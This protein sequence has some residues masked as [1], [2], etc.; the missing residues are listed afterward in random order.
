[1]RIRAALS[2]LPLRAVSGAFIVNSGLGKRSATPERAAQ[3]HGLAKGTYPQFEKM[4]PETFTKT[5]SWAELALGTAL[6]SPFISSRVAGIALG[7][8]A[9]GLL[10]LYWKT[11]GM[12]EETSVRPTEQGIGLAKDIWLLGIGLSLILDGGRG[13]S[14]KRTAKVRSAKR[15]S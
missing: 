12:H 8:F 5:L 10:G 2:H 6:L 13:H 3:I 15:A 4:A 11:P 7:S 9:S 1:M 14:K